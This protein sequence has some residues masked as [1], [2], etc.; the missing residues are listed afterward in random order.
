MSQDAAHDVAQGGDSNKIGVIAATF[1]VAGNMMGSGV[2]ML[3]ANLAAYGSISLI[4]WLLTSVG[5][6][7]LALTFAK[8]ANIDPAAGGPYAYTRKAF[9]D[10]MGYQTNMV[11]WVANVIGNVG[12]AVAGIG[13]LTHFVPALKNPYVAAFAQL[14]VIWLFAWANMLGPRLVGRIQ[15]FTTIMAL[16]PIIATALLGWFWFKPELFS[17]GWNV[18]GQSDVSAV[19]GTLNFTLWAFIGVESASVSAAVVR[20]PRRNVPIATISGVILAGVCYILSSSVIMGMIPNKAL[21]ASSAPF[22]DAARIALGDTAANAVALCAAL[23]CLGSLAGWTLLV[24]QSAKAAA[25]DGLFGNVFSRVNRKQVPAAGL[26]IVALIMSLMVLGTISPGASQQFGKLASIAVILTLLPYIYSCIAVKVLGYKVLPPNQYLLYII[27]GF[28]GAVYCM[29]ALIGS[30]GSQTRWSL[31]F[32]IATIVLYSA[33]ITRKREIEEGHV[34]TGGVSPQWIRW[35]TLVV[36]IAVLAVTFWLTV[37]DRH[38]TQKRRAPL[39]R[40]LIEESAPA[41]Q[42]PPAAV[43]P[44]SLPPA[45]SGALSAPRPA[46]DS[47][48]VE[49]HAQAAVSGAD[50][51]ASGGVTPASGFS[52]ISR[53]GNFKECL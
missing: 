11:Y 2:F 13:Y 28:V 45:L 32:V 49:A 22:A 5:A 24:G 33:A 25:D 53:S 21:V 17:A 19:G 39:P 40:H 50:A 1:M 26:F 48:G 34:H 23:G 52:G 10:Y 41:P 15:S 37:E 9:G 14:F 30:D 20:N 18:T 4:G 7:A 16:I 46:A 27:I 44:E 3:P 35:L 29:T 31:I 47:C 12:L 51:T 36:T 8:L 6:V 43:A 38:S 42:A